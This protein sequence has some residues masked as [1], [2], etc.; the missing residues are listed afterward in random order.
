MGAKRRSDVIEQNPL[1]AEILSR[2]GTSGEVTVERIESEL[3]ERERYDIVAALR[4]LQKAGAGAWVEGRRGSKSRFVWSRQQP[5]RASSGARAKSPAKRRAGPAAP[6]VARVVAPAVTPAVAQQGSTQASA[7]PLL[8]HSF[9]IR[10]GVLTSLRL[11]ADVTR[12]EIERLC[13]FLQAIPF[14]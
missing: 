4:E 8:E 3:V 1:A 2:F 11:P 13:R 9:H 14:H 6:A 12:D 7:P 10:K 5:P